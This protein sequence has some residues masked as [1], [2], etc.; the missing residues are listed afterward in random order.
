MRRRDFIAAFAGAMV[1]WPFAVRAQK[2]A[3]PVIGF[4]SIAAP[5]AQT[6]PFVS[7]FRQGLGELGYTDG[8]NVAIESRWADGRYDR[9]PALAADLARREVDMIAAVSGDA[10]IRAATDASAIIPVIFITGSDPVGSGLVASLARPGGH[11]TGI[12]IITTQLTSKRF[13]LLFELVPKASTI[14]LLLNPNTSSPAERPI[15]DM[16][17]AARAKGI[18]FAILKAA[19]ESEIDAAF[20]SLLQLHASALVVGTDAFFNSRR[21][22]LVALAARHAI[23]AIY[24]WRE[25]VAAG[26]L[27]SYGASLAGVYRQLGIYA[28]KILK[29]AKP[30]DLPVQQPDKFELVINLKTAAALGLAVPQSILA[31]TDEV[32]E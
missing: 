22:Q 21:E 32:I 7:A 12:S 9:L 25:F 17:E 18:Q 16:Q 26:G 8:E 10:T 11:L 13:E 28:G 1:G 2:K 31:R 3:M 14:V 24:E 6:T 23:P 19:T 4:L 27:I 29:G 15:L 5:G 20:A 30:A